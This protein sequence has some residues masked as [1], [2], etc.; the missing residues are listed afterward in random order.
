[1]ETAGVV[2]TVHSGYA[3]G[4]GSVSETFTT[5]VRLLARELAKSPKILRRLVEITR[6]MTTK[7]L[8]LAV[9]IVKKL[10]IIAMIAWL[11]L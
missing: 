2:P 7:Q 1:M 5:E 10:I 3:E 8:I 9:V 4:E 11:L 6:T